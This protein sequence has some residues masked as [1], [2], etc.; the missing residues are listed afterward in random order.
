M[1]ELQNLPTGWATV[2]LG[3]VCSQPQYGYTTKASN[4]GDLR[5]L[6]T[7]DITSGKINWETVPYCSENPDNSE[8]YTLEDGDILVSRAGSVGVSHLV[9]KPPLRAIFASY[10][11][12][13][14]TFIDG[15]FLG[16]F[17][18][19]PK[20]WTM[21]AEEKLGI[22]VPN[23]NATKLK[24]IGVPIPPA[25]EQHRIV[26]KIEKLFSE[27]NKG[28]ESLKKAR[29]QLGVY[30]QALLKKVFEG[31]L[32]EVW[33]AEHADEIEPADALLARINQEREALY[34]RQLVDWTAATT[35][36]EQNSKQGKRPTK[37]HKPNPVESL[38][39]TELAEFPELPK[40]WAKCLLPDF[41]NITMGQSPPSTT[42]NTNS[43]GLPFFQGKAEFGEISPVAVKYCS[44]P[45][46]VAEPGATLLSVRAPVGPTNLAKLRC[47]IGRGL[48][49]IHPLGN[50]PSSFILMMFRELQPRISK[51]GTGTTFT[52]I[53]RKYLDSLEINLPPLVE[54]RRIVRILEEQFSAISQVEREIDDALGRAEA[55]RQ[56]ILKKA[57]SGQLVPQD[58]ND[59]P[60]SV[61]LEL[62][63]AEKSARAHAAATAK[64]RRRTRA[65][66]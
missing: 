43:I 60:A 30:R 9:M 50:I 63:K 38:A 37:P 29:A 7:S 4:S 45:V 41:A 5:L 31:K 35:Q 14:K 58:P 39:K 13:F 42:Y 2:S 12:R 54:Q 20:Y 3:E 64:R 22:A 8:K 10:L 48:A 46:R 17:L 40:G 44:I 25:R 11:I 34:K 19:S 52:A 16:Y 49:A 65:T 18:Q 33:R 1:T 27:L 26:A 24:S 57:F 53:N 66:S 28:V 55:L 6:R 36:W 47:C 56:S 61:L 59:E 32:T 51:Q 21:I 23:V 15:R 62:I